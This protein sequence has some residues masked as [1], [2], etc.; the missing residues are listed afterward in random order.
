MKIQHLFHRFG[1]RCEIGVALAILMI[2]S[3]QAATLISN[4]FSSFAI[5]GAND[6]RIR[7][8]ITSITQT[9]SDNS[10]KSYAL[11]DVSVPI[12]NV[13]LGITSTLMVPKI[14]LLASIS[15][16]NQPYLNCTL[17]ARVVTAASASFTLGVKHF[18][19]ETLVRWGVCDNP[20][21]PGYESIFPA[22]QFGDVVQLSQQG[23]AVIGTFTVPAA[24]RNI[25]PGTASKNFAVVN[26]LENSN[27]KVPA[28][29]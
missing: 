5:N 27:Y 11:I 9:F 3:A 20:S 12:P 19:N 6:A 2:G 21:Q 22:L 28:L 18:N 1:K 13:S 23:G 26:L 17:D 4:S 15:R 29:H 14:K 8:Q 16:Q 24:P 7:G 10:Q 25:S